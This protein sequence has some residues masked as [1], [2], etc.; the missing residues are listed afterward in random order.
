[1]ESKKKA[2]PVKEE[3]LSMTKKERKGK[4]SVNCIREG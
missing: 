1:M 3:V 2:G 4:E